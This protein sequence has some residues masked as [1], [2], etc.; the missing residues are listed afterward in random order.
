L[1]KGIHCSCSFWLS[2]D[3][4]KY[5]LPSEII[6]LIISFI[7]SRHFFCCF[8]ES[9][10][11]EIVS[12]SSNN[13]CRFGALQIRG[14]HDNT[15]YNPIEQVLFRILRSGTEI[16]CVVCNITFGAAANIRSSSAAIEKIVFP[17]PNVLYPNPGRIHFFTGK[18]IINR[19]YTIPY[20]ITSLRTSCDKSLSTR[21][22]MTE[23]GSKRYFYLFPD[24]NTQDAHLG[25]RI[26]ANT[27]IPFLPGL[28]SF[29][30]MI[31]DIITGMSATIDQRNLLLFFSPLG[32]NIEDVT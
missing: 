18:K 7:Y 6:L 22:R 15:S 8:P 9:L 27:I 14:Q 29:A 13:Q 3:L 12:G 25:N 11:A 4:E 1:E 32:M 30:G 10:N 5:P 17:H 19:P 26:K 28:V 21:V 31:H 16:T 24:H 20:H 23:S 2:H